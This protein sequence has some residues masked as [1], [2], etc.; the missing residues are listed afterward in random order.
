[1]WWVCKLQ[2]SS[3]TRALYK[4]CELLCMVCSGC[5]FSLD[6]AAIV[7]DCGLHRSIFGSK[8]QGYGGEEFVAEMPELFGLQ[9]LEA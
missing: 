9:F 5:G 8:I 4:V 3:F 6:R 7:P 1:M 2:Y